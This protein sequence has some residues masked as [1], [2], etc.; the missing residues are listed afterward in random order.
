MSK[1]VSK[2]FCIVPWT[3]TFLSPQCERRLCCASREDHQF[4]NQYLD[5]NNSDDQ[6]RQ[7]N[8]VP[9][10]EYWDSDFIK[11]VR[12]RMLKGEEIPECK[13]CEYKELSLNTYREYFNENL[14]PH[15]IEEAIES[16]DIE[17]HTTMRP[18]SFDYRF[19]NTCN[20]KCR[21]CGEQLSSSWEIEKKNSDFH[22]P[23]DDFWMEAKYKAVMNKFQTEVAFPE[24]KKALLSGEV[25]EI[26]WV[27]GEPLIWDYHWDIMNLLIK[28]D[29]AKNIFVRYNTNLSIIERDG[30][31][32][33][34]DILPH[35]K[36][37]ILQAS[38]DAFGPVGEYIRTGLN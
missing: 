8:P 18:R 20:F 24:F 2:H 23:K 35:F 12:V 16:T 28:K 25:E 19:D 17:G 5:S 10:E 31:N 27:G 14:F 22:N 33:F 9:L 30:K 34:H 7:F 26:Y 15:L 29:L 38:I 21:M 1:K 32:L 4:V 11:D 3:H 6:S 37:Y 13:V 36:N